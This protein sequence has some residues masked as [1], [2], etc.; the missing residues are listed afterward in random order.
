[1]ASWGLR[2][3]WMAPR[4]VSTRD[5]RLGG[6]PRRMVARRAAAA[7]ESGSRVEAPSRANAL[8]HGP[9]QMRAASRADLVV[10]LAQ[11]VLGRVEQVVRA[12]FWVDR[13]VGENKSRLRLRP[14][15]RSIRAE[16]RARP[17]VAVTERESI[18]SAARWRSERLARRREAP[19]QR[20]ATPA[21]CS[22][23]RAI[24]SWRARRVVSSAASCTATAHRCDLLLC[25]TEGLPAAR[26][27]A[28]AETWLRGAPGSAGSSSRMRP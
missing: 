20:T 3:A 12:E 5:A 8:R 6:D 10:L 23:I 4:K 27:E 21:I 14:A 22:S 17:V 24:R 28:R 1:M 11:Q 9:S 25:A 15:R 26:W 7:I 18:W 16:R 2:P 19:R 13:Q